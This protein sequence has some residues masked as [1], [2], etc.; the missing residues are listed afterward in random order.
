[1]ERQGCENRE[2]RPGASGCRGRTAVRRCAYGSRKSRGAAP[3]RGD[4]MS[5]ISCRGTGAHLPPISNT[6]RQARARGGVGAGHTDVRPQLRTKTNRQ[7]QDTIVTGTPGGV[8]CG[9]QA[10][11]STLGTVVSVV[12]CVFG[13]PRAGGA[14][15]LAQALHERTCSIT[16][17]PRV[18]C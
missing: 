2:A 13:S 18:P 7:I 5:E 17:R 14:G 8:F 3:R 1:M 6:A 15:L 11:F 4:R 10:A 9:G 12:S 16:A